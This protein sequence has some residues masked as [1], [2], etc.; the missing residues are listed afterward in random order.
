[1]AIK[2]N[3]Y[4][5]QGVLYE[6]PLTIQSST[7]A[8]FDLTGYTMTGAFKKHPSSNTSYTI[9]VTTDNA[10][11]GVVTVSVPQSS[12]ANTTAGRYLYDVTI[13][14]TANVKTKVLEG[15]LTIKPTLS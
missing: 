15:V 10:Q 1:M 2:A 3:L 11:S 5:Y 13:V 4:V 6:T 7:G 12:T 8:T 14:N 9:N